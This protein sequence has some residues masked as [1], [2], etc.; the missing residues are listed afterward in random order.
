MAVL[1]SQA[2][3]LGA[4]PGGEWVISGAITADDTNAT[5]NVIEVPAG[6]LVT[7]VRLIITTL[8][9]TSSA[10]LAID[11]G[12]TS[13]DD[14][15]VAAADVTEAT[16]GTYRGS[17]AAAAFAVAPAGGKYYDSASFLTAKLSADMTAGEAYVIARFVN[18]GAL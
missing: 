11:I 12:D 5:K 7:D 15:W 2:K 1:T 16:V 6:T 18:V 4:A 17:N 8:F 3:R 9:A 14:G 13:N 10:P